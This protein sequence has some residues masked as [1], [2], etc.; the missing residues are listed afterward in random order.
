MCQLVGR[1]HEVIG[2]NW[3]DDATLVARD[4]LLPA[5]WLAGW[6]GN[7]FEWRGNAMDLGEASAGGKPPA[8]SKHH[9]RTGMATLRRRAAVA[10]RRWRRRGVDL[11][12]GAHR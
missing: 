11:L 6:S 7:R 9:G 8:L 12:R 5:L 3:N 2:K 10:Y 1:R 4:L